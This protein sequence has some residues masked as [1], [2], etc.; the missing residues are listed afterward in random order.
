MVPTMWMKLDALPLTANG[1]LD[2]K[3]LPEPDADAAIADRT[4]VAPRTPLETQLADVWRRVLGAGEIGVHDNLFFLGADSLHVFRITARL[5]EQGLHIEAKDLLRHPTVAEI[6]EIAATRTEA[7]PVAERAGAPS[8]RAFRGGA[9][10]GG[11]S[12]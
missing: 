10:R 9:R 8:L 4:I 1:K 5:I 3:A 6:A 2:R 7:P 12:S 11:A